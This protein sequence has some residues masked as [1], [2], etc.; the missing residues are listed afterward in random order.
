VTSTLDAARPR[1]AMVLAAGLGTR[2][3]PITDERPKPLVEVLGR[4]LLEHAMRNAARAGAR[5]IAVNTHYLAEQVA[6]E[7]KRVARALSVDVAVSHEPVILGTG[8]GIRRMRRLLPDVDGPV[9]IVNA[10]ALIDLDTDALVAAHAKHRPISTLVLKE[11]ADQERYGTIG[12]DDDARVRDFVGRVPV[13]APVARR[14]MFCGV[15]LVEEAVFDALDDTREMC[16]NKEAYPKLLTADARVHGV[17]C[18]TEFWDVGTAER[19]KDANARLL[20]GRA[21]F[22]FSDETDAR[23]VDVVD[24]GAEIVGPVVV[25]EGARLGRG[26][27][28]GPSVVVGRGAVIGAGARVKDSVVLAGARV[29]AGEDVSGLVVGG[30]V[31]A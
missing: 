28:V 5:A 14:G 1:R 21:R 18:T 3:R 22:R 4:T 17:F 9:L 29:D 19:L 24:E 7:A 30:A 11:T 12:V 2:L 27:I 20:D 10:D 23:G 26:A 6:D 13:T 25:A 16:I 31:R 8:G 15:H